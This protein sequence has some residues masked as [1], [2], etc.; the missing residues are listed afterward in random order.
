AISRVRVSL[1]E[2]VTF[3]ATASTDPDGSI[4]SYSWDFGDGTGD[5]G[6][7]VVHAYTAPGTYTITLTVTDNRGT[8]NDAVGYVNVNAPPAASFNATPASA[9]PC[10]HISLN[11]SGSSHPEK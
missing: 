2:L 10:V 1:D 4:A 6:V 11:A 7:S 3:D 5:Q 9:Y 8:S